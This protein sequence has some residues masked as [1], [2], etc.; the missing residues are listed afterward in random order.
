MYL[1]LLSIHS[2]IRWIFLAGLILLLLKSWAGWRGK[3]A[4]GAFDNRLGMALTIVAD[5]QLLTGA[6]LYLIFSPVT[7]GIWANFYKVLYSPSFQFFGIFHFLMMMAAVFLL[8][9]MRRQTKSTASDQGKY[10]WAFLSTALALL[11]VIL[12]IPW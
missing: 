5:V 12:A 6:L 7:N 10:R 1:I 2:V 9:W 4:W 11:L 8:H 3:R